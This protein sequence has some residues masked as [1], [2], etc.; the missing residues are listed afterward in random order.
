MDFLKQ[1]HYQL[2]GDS[3]LPKLVFLHGY[4]GSGVVQWYEVA[5][6]MKNDY[7]VIIPD[8]LCS[9]VVVVMYRIRCLVIFY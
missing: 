1:F 3:S 6:R 9:G 7:D 2:Y 8:L 5:L 4:G